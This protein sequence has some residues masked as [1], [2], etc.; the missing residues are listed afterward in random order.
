MSDMRWERWAAASGVAF[1]VLAVIGFLF[2]YDLPKAGSSGDEVL[3]YFR[4]N[5][6]AVT[7]QA[8]FFGLAV[9]AFLWFI[10]TLASAIRRAENDPA[11]RIPAITVVAGATAAALY[12]GGEAAILSL[13]KN[14]DQLEAGSALTL[15]GASTTAFLLTDFVAATFVT[16]VALGVMRT[17][18]L[19]TWISYAGAV[20]VVIALIDGVGGILSDSDTFGS[21]GFIGTISFL[22]FLAWTAVTSATLTQRVA[23]TAP[24]PRM[25]PTG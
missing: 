4:E 11:G 8:L 19:P 25:A 13:A 17:A 21:G 10:G 16:A 3:T 14:A 15:H 5:D 12:M 24:T 7:W 22:A 1:V 6:T 18:L 20:F 2:A 23:A 9:I